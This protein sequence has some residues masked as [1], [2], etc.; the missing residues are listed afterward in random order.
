MSEFSGLWKHK[1]NPACSKKMSVFIKL[2][3][4]TIKKKKKKKKKK[5]TTIN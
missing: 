5:T 2:K 3:L 4:D 1:N